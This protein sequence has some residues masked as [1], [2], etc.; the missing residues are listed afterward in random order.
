MYVCIYRCM[1]VYIY[2]DIYICI[3]IIMNIW[4]VSMVSSAISFSAPIGPSNRPYMP[5]PCGWRNSSP[6][7][8]AKSVGT[9][10]RTGQMCVESYIDRNEVQVYIYMIYIY[11]YSIYTYTVYS[12]YIYIYVYI[13]IYT[14][15]IH[16]R[17]YIYIQY[18]HI[19]PSN[20]HLQDDLDGLFFWSF[21]S[22]FWTRTQTLER[23]ALLDS[24]VWSLVEKKT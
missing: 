4:W 19:I 6:P 12:M 7:R 5:H 2:T 9:F 24:A 16:T 14:Y 15:M 10:G 8:C 17:I 22:S 1:Y 3:Y 11:I 18:I 23:C 13:Y 20:K 21:G